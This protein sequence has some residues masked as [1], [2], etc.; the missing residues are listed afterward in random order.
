MKTSEEQV[1]EES[2]NPRNSISKPHQE[3]EASLLSNSVCV[4]SLSLRPPAH[5]ALCILPSPRFYF[6]FVAI[7]VVVVASSSSR[8][9][10]LSPCSKK[11][12]KSEFAK[13]LRLDAE[14]KEN[15]DIC[16]LIKVQE[17]PTTTTNIC[18]QR[19]KRKREEKE[20]KTPQKI[21]QKK[22]KRNI[23]Q[24]VKRVL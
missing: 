1:Q 12:V 7:V 23:V 21:N 19:K 6:V 9:A 17:F 13:N 22:A 14:S 4:V 24:Q 5:T 15:C 20:E 10:S 2:T 18:N 11:N 3:E 8:F 16:I